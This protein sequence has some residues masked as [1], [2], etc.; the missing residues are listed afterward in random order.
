MNFPPT[1]KVRV[2]LSFQSDTGFAP[3]GAFVCLENLENN[4]AAYYRNVTVIDTLLPSPVTLSVS[5]WAKGFPV[6]WELV[7][8][9]R[10]DSSDR[11]VP[12]ADTIQLRTQ[13][14]E[15]AAASFMVLSPG[16]I[17]MAFLEFV[18]DFSA[19][20]EGRLAF[21]CYC[22]RI[23]FISKKEERVLAK[24]FAQRLKSILVAANIPD[25][26]ISVKA[27]RSRMTQ[28]C[29]V[30]EPAMPEEE[31]QK[32]LYTVTLALKK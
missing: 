30:G 21:S 18:K 3:V 24:H 4:T 23:A 11:V 7:F 29:T 19:A 2:V 10:S 14:G 6:Q 20:H 25:H 22:S 26:R 32:D 16:R 13:P 5:T 1:G 27:R 15:S 17:P 28:L 31:R 9:N 8:F 12:F